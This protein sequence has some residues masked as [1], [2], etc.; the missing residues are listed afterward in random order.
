MM[1]VITSPR[2]DTKQSIPISVTGMAQVRANLLNFCIHANN[3]SHFLSSSQYSI[4]NKMT[5]R[6]LQI[7]S[8]YANQLPVLSMSYY[9]QVVSFKINLH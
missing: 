5:A 2:V 3:C 8:Q 4:S 6:T 1:I 9:K 7:L